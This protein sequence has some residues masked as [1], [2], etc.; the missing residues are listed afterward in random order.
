MPGY[1]DRSLTPDEV[2]RI[3]QLALSDIEDERVLVIIPDGTRTA[4]IPEMFRCIHHE[5]R[6]R[7]RTLDFLVALGTHQPMS[8]PEHL[9]RLVGV[10]P[11][12]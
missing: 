7:A 5:L 12:E 11:E 3:V 10:E 1:T 4:P 6:D 2:Y 8:P 9:N